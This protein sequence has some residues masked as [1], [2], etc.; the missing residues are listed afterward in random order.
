MLIKDCMTRHPVLV[1]PD[2]SASEAQRIMADNHIRHLPVVG[3]GKRLKGLVTRQRLALKPQELVSL[4]VWEISRYLTELRVSKIMLKAADVVTIEPNRTIE[5]AAAVLTEHRIG[6]LPVVEEGNVV[7]G[8]VTQVDLLDSFQEM[9]GLPADGVRVTVRIPNRRGEFAR[10][11]GI[12]ADHEW[13][14]TGIG[15]FP[16]R[17]NP[18]TYETVIKIPWVSQEDVKLAFSTFPDHRIVDIRT[19][20]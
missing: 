5:R 17:G 19:A 18:D 1:A 13:S 14:V 10:L 8:I 2:I 11:M 7:V 4:N 6:C 15:T 12:L 20:D 16:T 9:L 3:D